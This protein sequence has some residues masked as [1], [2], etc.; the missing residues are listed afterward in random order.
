VPKI[1]DRSARRAEIV[2]AFLRL[3]TRDGIENASSRAVATELGVASGALWYYFEDF[4]D[5]LLEAFRTVFDVTNDRI[6]AATSARRGLRA[7]TAMLTEILPLAKLTHDEALVVVS[8]WGR[9]PS[10]PALGRYQSEAENQWRATLRD[11]LRDARRDRELTAAAP[12]DLLAD[13]LLVLAIGQQVE[14]VLRTEVAEPTRQWQIIGT[15]L[16]P[17]A[18]RSG[19]TALD[20]RRA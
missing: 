1:V 13:V 12:I 11:H 16:A 19:R 14:H 4:D 10:R 3:V 15:V 18:T 20:D 2:S 5:V 9:V 8:L 17:W 6:A 7:L